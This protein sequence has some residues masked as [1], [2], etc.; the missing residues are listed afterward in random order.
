MPDGPG[1]DQRNM[2]NVKPVGYEE[3]KI[4]NAPNSLRSSHPG[5]CPANP[6]L[7]GIAKDQGNAN[8][9]REHLFDC[10]LGGQS[11]KIVFCIGIPGKHRRWQYLQ[12]T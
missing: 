4:L 5:Q 1:L 7:D 11:S 9:G 12:E 2:G 3:E 6:S 10:Q 8:N